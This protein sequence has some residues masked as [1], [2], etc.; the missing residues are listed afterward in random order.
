MTPRVSCRLSVTGIR[1][2]GILLPPGDSALLTVGLPGTAWTPAGI[3]RSAHPSHGRIGCPL[4]PEAQR[5]SHSRSDPSGR[6]SPPLPGA[7]PYRPGDRSISRSCL[8]RGVIEGSL[9]FT[10]PAFPLACGPR[11]ERGLLGLAPRASHPGRQ[12]LRRT[13]GRGTGIEHSPGATRPALPDLQSVHSLAMCDLVSHNRHRHDPVPHPG[14]PG[15]VARLCPRTIQSGTRARPGKAAKGN[16]YLK[17]VLGDAA[18][19]AGKTSTFLGER[20]R[21]LV[22]RRGKL[23][24]LVGHRPALQGRRRLGHRRAHAHQPGHRRPRHGHRRPEAA[25]RGDIPL[26]PGLP[27]H[28]IGLR[29]LLHEE[30]Y[31]EIPG[32]DRNL[33]RQCR[34]GIVLRDLQERTHPHP[35]LAQWR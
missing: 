32:P 20:Y 18:A 5:C 7:R 30:Q 3:P 6:R 24:A 9:A 33:L 11:M 26:R 23:K 34:I 10:R 17:G 16:P 12:D 19:A 14:A 15:V 2:L 35:P 13:P 4:Y 22:K 28:L 27:V 29:R 1:L 25:R 21:R 8:L 31:P